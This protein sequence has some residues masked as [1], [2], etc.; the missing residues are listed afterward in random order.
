MPVHSST[1]PPV[2]LSTRPLVHLSTRP[3]VHLFLTPLATLILLWLLLAPHPA[4]AQ[5]KKI[6]VFGSSVAKGSGD[7]TGVGGYSGLIK[8]LLENR[9]WTV[10]NVSRG[11]DNTVKILPRFQTELLPEKPAFVIIGLSL[12][13]EGIVSSSELTRNR[14]SER[15]RSGMVHLINLCRENG[16]IPVVVNCY[17][18]SDF[19][20]AQYEAIQKMNL[21]INTWDVP[22]VNALGA[23]DNGNGQWADG[24][25]HDKS[26][27]NEKGHMEIFHAFVPGLFDALAAGKKY[28]EKVRSAKYLEITAGASRKPLVYLPGD[29][30]HSFAV[31]FQVKCK[32]DGTIAT[33]IGVNTHSSFGVRNGRIIYHA[34]GKEILY[35]D[36]TGENKGWQHILLS[37]SYATGKTTLYVN[38]QPAGCLSGPLNFGE[39][40]LG[41]S[42]DEYENAPA[43]AGYRELLIYRSA[44]N[45]SEAEALYYDQLLQSSLEIYAPLTDDEFKSGTSAENHAQ[46][47]SKLLING[48]HL[49]PASDQSGAANK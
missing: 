34:R 39:F 19:G 4:H 46:S 15:F 12:G 17:A 35:A 47:L 6:A 31:G 29:T 44:L 2:H 38:G 30:I 3:L 45:S 21:V 48:E 5:N 32:D 41:G 28:P 1:R 8:I 18:R 40:I 10:V 16:M 37:H 33:L 43:L 27:P 11:G 24:Y 23:I 14:V 9:G 20:P 49:I 22:S 13:N 26:H 42:G 36:T 25:W 7:T